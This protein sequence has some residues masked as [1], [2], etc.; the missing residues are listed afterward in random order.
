LAE[1]RTI[2]D[3]DA[4]R[5]AVHGADPTKNLKAAMEE[6]ASVNATLTA[7]VL[8]AQLSAIEDWDTADAIEAAQKHLGRLGEQLHFALALARRRARVRGKRA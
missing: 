7:H 5:D 1:D 3:L 2:V 8:N 4:A 6:A